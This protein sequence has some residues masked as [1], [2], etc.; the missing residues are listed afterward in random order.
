MAVNCHTINK[1][2]RIISML[3][4]LPLLLIGC[5]EDQARLAARNLSGTVVIMNIGNTGSAT[6]TGGGIGTGFL[7][8]E[9][10]I[11]TNNHVVDGGGKIRVVGYRDGKDYPATVLAADKQADIAVLR[12]DE[13]DEFREHVSPTLLSWG[14]SRK[15]DVGD[16]VWSMG[17]PYG[18]AWTVAQGLVSH[19]LRNAKNGGVYYIQTT[20]QIYPGNSGGPLLDQD[21]RV[22]AINSA[23]VGKEGYFGMAIPSDY[24]RKVVEDLIE[25]GSVRRAI[26]GITVGTSDDGHDVEVKGIASGSPALAAGLLPGDGIMQVR[27]RATGGRAIDVYSS[28]DLISE[29]SLLDPGDEVELLVSRDGRELSVGFPVRE[30]AQASSAGNP[31]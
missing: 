21:G 14:E 27:T 2:M 10:T 15:L 9:N 3:L 4:M 5:S 29:I 17:N 6:P 19:K 11:V 28:D 23:I 16:T 20:T 30:N 13:W 1:S 31:G 8:G 18:L 25:H 12:L 7:I 24:A 22:V 26:M